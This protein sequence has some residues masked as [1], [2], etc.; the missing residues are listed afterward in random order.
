[1][2]PDRQPGGG[3]G[4]RTQLTTRSVQRESSGQAPKL[5]RYTDEDWEERPEDFL[6]SR[7]VPDVITPLYRC[8]QGQE[9]AFHVAVARPDTEEAR[10]RLYH[11]LGI[12]LH[13]GLDFAGATADAGQAKILAN[14]LHR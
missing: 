10:H 2:Q 3:W 9:T 6:F 14:R 4:L 8:G 13:T 12:S 7:Q 5:A 1:M 11:T